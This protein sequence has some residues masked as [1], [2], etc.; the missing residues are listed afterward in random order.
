MMDSRKT[1]SARET[2]F[3]GNAAEGRSLERFWREFQSSP[4]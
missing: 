4:Q 3:R 1:I 2:E